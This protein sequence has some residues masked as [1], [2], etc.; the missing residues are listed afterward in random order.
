MAE[1]NADVVHFS[2]VTRRTHRRGMAPS[3]CAGGGFME[4]WTHIAG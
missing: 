4:W 1:K 3:D 2:V